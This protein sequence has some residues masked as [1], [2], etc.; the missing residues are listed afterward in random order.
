MKLAFN[1]ITLG[2]GLPYFLDDKTKGLSGELNN[3]SIKIPRTDYS[4][5]IADYLD[6]KI[7]VFTGTFVGSDQED[8]RSKKRDLVNMLRKSFLF[9]LTD[10]YVNN[11]GS[12]TVHE[13]YEF[14]G[15]IIDFDCNLEL[16]SNMGR[17]RLQVF[18]EDP[19]LYLTT[20]VTDECEVKPRGFTFPLFFPFVFTG[21]DNVMILDNTGE[22]DVYPTITIHGGGRNFEIVNETSDLSNK[23][24][25]YNA[26]LNGIQELVLTPN[27][28][29]AVKARVGG[30][31]VVRNT[32]SNWEALKLKPGQNVL[33]FFLEEGTATAETLASISFKPAFLGI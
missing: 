33:T 7:R 30:I 21:R 15:K 3:I 31:S 1:S 24:F 19:L 18:C 27:V 2:G 4:K 28:T 17:Y 11:D 14:T 22:V 6:P 32:N 13:T 9:T 10:D 8:F 20:P 26:S 16:R 25:R 12:T 5:N 23:V 29:E